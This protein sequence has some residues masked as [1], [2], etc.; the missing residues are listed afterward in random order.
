MRLLVYDKSSVVRN[1]FVMSLLPKGF[2]VITVKEKKEILSIFFSIPF[3]VAVI[4]ID[5]YDEEMIDIIKTLKTDDRYANTSIIVHVLDPTK[6]FIVL[7]MEIGISGYLFKPFNDKELYDRLMNILEK[8]NIDTSKTKM[9]YVTPKEDD[10]VIVKFRSNLLNKVITANVI[11][12]SAISV[13]FQF[14]QDI[15]SEVQ[16]K[17]F[18]SNFKIQIGSSRVVATVFVS[19]RKDNICTVMFHEITPFDLN[20][21]CKY[22]YEANLEKY[23]GKKD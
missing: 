16:L 23:L 6:N 15:S 17:Q 14:N 5:P 18:M 8:A 20:T 11:E 19:S 2:D 13:K 21:V 10:N 7:L 22:I 4:E 1:S 9:V 3:T 12:I